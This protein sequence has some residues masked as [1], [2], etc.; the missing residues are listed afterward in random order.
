[1][2]KQIS[3]SDA[4][5]SFDDEVPRGLDAEAYREYYEKCSP[6][7][8]TILDNECQPLFECRSCGEIFRS[9]MFFISHKRTFCR[10]IPGVELQD[11]RKLGVRE[12]QTAAKVG[13]PPKKRGPKPKNSEAVKGPKPSKVCKKQSGE[14]LGDHSGDVYIKYNLPDQTNPDT[15]G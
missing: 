3:P 5:S 1:M 14:T 15:R 12:P 13:R 9:L 6:R 11:S 10:E 7:G 8:K 4:I 2:D